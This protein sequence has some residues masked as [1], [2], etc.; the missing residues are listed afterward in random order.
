MRSSEGHTNWSFGGRD[1]DESL[2]QVY[3]ICW[4]YKSR[5]L[6]FL[7]PPWT[8]IMI[9]HTPFPTPH[10]SIDANAEWQF[11]TSKPDPLPPPS[12]RSQTRHPTFRKSRKKPLNIRSQ[13]QIDFFGFCV[14]YQR[15]FRP[16]PRVKDFF[17]VLRSLL[18]CQN[19]SNAPLGP[20]VWATAKKIW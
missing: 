17:F 19:A 6:N 7:A 14:S 8:L 16:F 11:P 5:H 2:W 10:K 9:P 20:P 1:N 18:F 13:V 12:N 15:L 4:V 3:G